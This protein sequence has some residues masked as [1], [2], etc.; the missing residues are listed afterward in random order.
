[1]VHS[2]PVRRTAS[3]ESDSRSELAE[4][5]SWFSEPPIRLGGRNGADRAG[6]RNARYDII[7]FGYFQ[8]GAVVSIELRN[9]GVL[10]L[11]ELSRL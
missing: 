7:L 10:T 2:L 4:E 1:M 9:I 11:D 3:C 6:Y 8:G 5:T